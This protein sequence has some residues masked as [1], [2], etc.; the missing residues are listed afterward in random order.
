MRRL[1]FLLVLLTALSGSAWAQEDKKTDDLKPADPDTGESTVEETTLGLLP[2]PFEKQ[3]IKFAITYIGEVVGNPTGGQKQ[4]AVYED[5]INFAVDA[6]LEKL[7]GAKQLAFHANIFQIDGGG[8]SRGDLLNYMMVSGIEALPTTRLYEMW[9]EQKW[10]TKLALR[11]G[12]LAADTEFM[13]AKYTDVFTNA[14]LGWPAGL[15]L[16]L[17]SGGPSPPLATMGTRLRADLTEHFTLVGAVFDGNAAGPGSNDPQL[18][19][20]Y[21]L[22]FRV[23][24]PPLVLGEM[25]FLWNA[26]KGDPGLAGKFK[27]GGWRHFGDF[28]S[29]RFSSSGASLASVAPDGTPAG[30][31][32]DF[33]VYSSFEQKLYRVGKDADRGI[34]IFAR[35]SYSP[36]DR[37][38]IDL[39]AD[40]GIELVGLSDQRPHDKFGVAAGYARLSNWARA[41]DVDFQQI[42]GPNWPTRS[43][44]SLVTIVYQYEVRAGWTL[45]P[46]FQYITHPGGGATDPLGADPGK[47][48]KD[49][50]VFGLRTVLKF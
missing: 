46:N 34:G 23:N 50:A 45:Q 1:L 16:N 48:L 47:V 27:I 41:L 22:N 2:N 3:G 42:H 4:S 10:G 25:Q 7:I 49:A 24:D 19:D 32:G 8:L 17:P 39:Y 21:G 28:A 33:G 44:E 6:D 43:F 5:R 18:R 14:S 36:P 13:T 9:L 35:A 12:Q 30:L 11:A 31:S 15:S 29:E 38:L 26:E 40:A 20:H 37:N